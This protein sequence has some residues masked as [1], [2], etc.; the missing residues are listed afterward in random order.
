MDEFFEW[1]LQLK[2]DFFERVLQFEG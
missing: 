1:V 2:D